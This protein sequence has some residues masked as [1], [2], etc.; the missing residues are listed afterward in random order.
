VEAIL[1][2]VELED[3]DRG[4]FVRFCLFAYSGDYEPP[5][6]AQDSDRGGRVRS[7]CI[8]RRKWKSMMMIMSTQDRSVPYPDGWAMLEKTLARQSKQYRE[9]YY[10]EPAHPLL[11][12]ALL[13]ERFKGKTCIMISP[14]NAL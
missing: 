14:K 4:T 3:V 7:I 5:A 1:E 6:L 8:K 9:S 2:T 11:T 10:K 13:R 12:K